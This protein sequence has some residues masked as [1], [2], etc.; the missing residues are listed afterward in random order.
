MSHGLRTGHG[1]EVKLAPEKHRSSHTDFPVIVAPAASSRGTTVASRDGTKP[2]TVADPLVI[3]TPARQMLS[4]NATV[5][6][7]SGPSAAPGTDVV[8]YQPP[9]GLSAGSDQA[10]WGVCG[11][12]AR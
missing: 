7:A 2:S 6:P 9:S 10:R 1:R 3:G 4:F 5:R 12:E 11:A 8:T